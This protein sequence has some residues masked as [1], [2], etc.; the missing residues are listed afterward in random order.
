MVIDLK[1]FGATLI[2]RQ[3]GRE[4]FLALQSM[5]GGLKDNEKIEIDFKGILTF[6]P[7]W[8]DEFLTPLI[9]IYD[10]RLILKTIKNPSVKATLEIIEQTNGKKFKCII[11]K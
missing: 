8:A 9:N 1:K 10:K 5:L 2:S 4:A 7:S 11:K 3:T 6:S